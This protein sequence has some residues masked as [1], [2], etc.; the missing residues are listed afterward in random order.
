MMFPSYALFS[1]IALYAS[2]ASAATWLV[3]VSNATAGL[4]FGPNNIVRQPINHYIDRR[5][6]GLPLSDRRCGR[7]DHV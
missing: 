4:E 7:L 6:D 2:A 1:G 5:T 3:D